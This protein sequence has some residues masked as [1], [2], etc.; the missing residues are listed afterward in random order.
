M[1]TENGESSPWSS[2]YVDCQ[3][4]SNQPAAHPGPLHSFTAAWQLTWSVVASDSC[5]LCLFL[6]SFLLWWFYTSKHCFLFISPP[7]P[8]IPPSLPLDPSATSLPLTFMSFLFQFFC[9]PLSFISVACMR[10]VWNC[11]G[12]H[13]HL[14]VEADSA[15]ASSHH[16]FVFLVCSLWVGWPSRLQRTSAHVAT[17]EWLS[18]SSK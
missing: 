14:A 11:L 7:Y 15:I 13:G 6:F 17:A 5:S 3:W 16:C 2:C 10:M 9:D 8:L 4:W 12:E 1:E 18:L